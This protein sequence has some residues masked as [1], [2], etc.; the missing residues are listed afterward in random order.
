MKRS[1]LQGLGIED[2]ELIDKIL[3]ENSADI[4]R[5]K[6]GNDELKSQIT[7]LQTQLNEKTTELTALKESTKDYES[8][9]TQVT[10]LTTDKTN[11]QNE[12]T[13]KVTQIQKTHAIEGAVRDAKAKSLKAVMAHLDMDKITFE[14]GELGGLS[15]QL[16]ALKSGEDTAFL[17][18][19]AQQTSPAGTH[20]NSPPNGGNGG[21]PAS[22]K[23][24]ADA[25]AAKLNSNK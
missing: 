1:F 7:Q 2:K 15:D 19:E 4:G 9:K 18:G 3:D 25:I 14:N 24:F 13:T 6:G 12:L 10:Q 20:P 22:G 5:A 17:F 23:S 16:D 8:L 21:N 11:L